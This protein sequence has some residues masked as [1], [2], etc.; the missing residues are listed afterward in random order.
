MRRSAG[1]LNFK[2]CAHVHVDRKTGTESLNM[3]S[4]QS[5]NIPGLSIIKYSLPKF[6]WVH[7]ILATPEK[8]IKGVFH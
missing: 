5:S 7:T 2:S 6:A 4:T 8:F 1:K 3:W